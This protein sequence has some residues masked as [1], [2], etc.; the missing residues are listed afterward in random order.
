ME[1]RIKNMVCPRCIS[2]VEQALRESGLKPESVELGRVTLNES[3]DDNQ[4]RVLDSKLESIGFE[5]LEGTQPKL[6]LDI[7]NLLSDYLTEIEK[8]NEMPKKSEYLSESL[9][10][11]YS[12]LSTLFTQFEH[13]P[14]EKF[15]VRLKIERAKEL[16]EEPQNTISQIAFRLGYSSSQY[17]SNQFNSITGIPPSQW[18]SQNNKRSGRQDI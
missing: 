16:L 8:G 1:L 18:R 10:K 5:R 12:Y 17:F 13:L 6:V 2:A 9:Y 4:L 14:I 7:K 11:N 3:P 15:W